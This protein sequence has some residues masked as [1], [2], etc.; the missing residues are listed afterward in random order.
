[1]LMGH[2]TKDDI[3]ARYGSKKR[4]GT[5]DLEQL[6]N[7]S[8]PEIRFMTEA[9]LKAKEA[10]DAGDLITVKPWLSRSNWSTYYQQ[11]FG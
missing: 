8:S 6:V 9:L 10:A 2:S 5:W 11:K 3:P 1:M 4:L 7:A